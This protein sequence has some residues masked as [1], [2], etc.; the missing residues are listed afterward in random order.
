ML[1]NLLK[2]ASLWSHPRLG[3]LNET[4]NASSP[5]FFL[6]ILNSIFQSIIMSVDH[7]L[8][9]QLFLIGFW[10]F[11]SKIGK[12][13]VYYFITM[14][15]IRMKIMQWKWICARGSKLTT[16]G[17]PKNITLWTSFRDV[18]RMSTGQFSKTVWIC[19]N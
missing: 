14:G 19:S 8:L 4:R 7:K 16:L 2:L 10:L 12:R 3:N 11:C 5:G 9:L 13:L 1:E 18:L 6:K 17:R 15:E